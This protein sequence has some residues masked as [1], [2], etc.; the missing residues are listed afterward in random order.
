[1]QQQIVPIDALIREGFIKKLGSQ[2][3]VAA[4]FVS[5]PDKTR[6][7]QRLQQKE[8]KY[9]YMFLLE[10]QVTAASTRYST[11][12]LARQGVPVQLSADGKQ[13]AMARVI[14]VDFDIEV[15]YVTNKYTGIDT[16]SVNGF[17]R[18]WMF[19]RR[20]GSVNFTVN[21]GLTSFPVAYTAMESITLP[22]RESPAD[23]EPVYQIVATLT[24]QGYVSEP[25]TGT[26]GRINEIILS[27]VVPTSGLPGEKFYP[28]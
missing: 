23:Q 2:F 3:N 18:R 27:D 7:I 26:R 14:P 22:P 21:Y 4:A 12:R 5:S 11:N 13:Y 9:P 6:L 8:L 28:F 19:I 20:N 16:D 24:V 25:M 17:L 15:T 1:M 10:Q